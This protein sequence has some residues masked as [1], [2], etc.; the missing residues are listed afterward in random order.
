M[1]G[2]GVDIGGVISAGTAGLIGVGTMKMIG[3]TAGKFSGG[4][5]FVSHSIVYRANIVYLGS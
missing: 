5:S 1:A 2:N 4:T 3:D